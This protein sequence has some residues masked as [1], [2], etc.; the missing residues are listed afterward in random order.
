MKDGHSLQS[1]APECYWLRRISFYV[2]I[3][4][5]K[6]KLWLCQLQPLCK[7]LYLPIMRRRFLT[8]HAHPR[9]ISA[10]QVA[11]AGVRDE[12][13]SRHYAPLEFPA[14]ASPEAVSAMM[15]AA[16][17]LGFGN[18]TYAGIV[19]S[20]VHDTARVNSFKDMF[21]GFQKHT[22]AQND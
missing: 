21:W 10:K 9:S 11:T 4:Y 1:L 22:I 3:V 16:E 2:H 6:H 7:P 14:V 17:N 20:K 12:G 13:T 15:V 18:R 19:H 5:P 8:N